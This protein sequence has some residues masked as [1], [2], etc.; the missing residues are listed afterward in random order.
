MK[1]TNA[2]L[3]GMAE[4]IVP[5]LKRTDIIGY[6]AARNYRIISDLTREFE[7]RKEELILKYGT[8]D[9][10]D[11]GGETGSVTVRRDSPEFDEFL[12]E[13]A[14][15]ADAEHEPSFY[16]VRFDEAIGKLSG[17]ELLAIDFMFEE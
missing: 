14:D 16:K 6:A 12:D 10:D 5:H 7:E 1:Y 15:W 8:P 2:Q 13:I 11:D 4:A 9:T 3:E 17:E